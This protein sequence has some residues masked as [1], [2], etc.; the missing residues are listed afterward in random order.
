VPDRPRARPSAAG[1]LALFGREL[2]LERL[3]GALLV[4]ASS[5][6]S[7]AI[8]CGPPGVG[9]SAS[10]TEAVRRGRVAGRSIR[11]AVAGPSP[12]HTLLAPEGDAPQTVVLD[13]AHQLDGDAAA[14]LLQRVLD[15]KLRCLLGSTA[16]DLLPEPLDWLWR[17]GQLVRIDID[18]L[19]PDDVAAWLTAELGAA[20]DSPT[21]DALM[22]D[23][24]GLP[25]LLVDTLDALLRG[26]GP[27][28]G[29][30]SAESS[31]LVVRS[32]HGRLAGPLPCPPALRQ[33]VA[34]RL[35]GLDDDALAALDCVCVTGRLDHDSAVTTVSS[36]SLRELHRRRLVVAQV[37]RDRP[38]LAVAAGA[39]RRVRLAEL[40][41]LGVAR[42]A[43]HLL[44][45]V[46]GGF[47]LDR[48]LWAALAMAPSATVPAEATIR[49]LIADKRLDDAELLARLATDRGDRSA[50]VPLA[51]LRAERGDRAGAA[52]MLADLLDGPELERRVQVQATAELVQ[53][54]LW[55]LDQTGPALDLAERAVEQT[56]GLDGPAAP[57]LLAALTHAGRIGDA[58]ALFD[59]LAQTGRPLEGLVHGAGAVALALSGRLEQAIT[60]AEEGLSRAG[61]SDP[62][63]PAA[64]PE[65]QILAMSLALTESGRVADADRF[66]ADW[67]ALARRHPPELAWMA[68]ARSRVA[69]AIGDLARADLHGREAEGILAEVDLVVPL[70][71]SIASQLLVAGLRGDAD[72]CARHLERLDAAPRSGVVFLETDVRRA[73]AWARHAVGDTIGARHALADAAEAAERAGN[74]VLALNAWHDALRLGERQVAPASVMRVAATVSGRWSAA[75]AAHAK[76]LLRDDPAGLLEAAHE[77]AAAGRLLE[78]AEGAAEALD[79]AGRKD[80]RALVREAATALATW[81]VVCPD[82]R[83]PPLQSGRQ[84][85]LTGREREVAALAAGGTS[86]RRIADELGISVRTVDNFLSRAYSKLGVRSRSEL[87]SA[88]DRADL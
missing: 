25:G 67:Y 62:T 74:L 59:T 27:V 46:P 21:L 78:A 31:G 5:A 12:L 38:G 26:D 51:H 23:C 34:N 14:D 64:D 33:R 71:W 48:E 57:I 19:G 81:R 63:D 83:T 79:R 8:V 45:A 20:P 41:P 36:S 68:L 43:T 30:E 32:G 9:V 47:P 11:H 52:R 22:S 73:R 70:R 87:A 16:P 40:G 3:A 82:A 7:G 37:H 44:E 80:R 55:D 6:P 2:V 77:L 75:A 49:Q 60:L 15:G 4:G 72:A 54:L 86:S 65:S 17:S 28:D 61:D 66:T 29:W 69:L 58:V 56:G 76:A 39:I 50:T 1:V 42:V 10:L 24:A 18:P 53:I 88:L 13:D 35:S 85:E 84:V